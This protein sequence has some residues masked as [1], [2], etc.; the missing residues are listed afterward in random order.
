M[1]PAPSFYSS[2]LYVFLKI[3]FGMC[4]M[5]IKNRLNRVTVLNR[6]EGAG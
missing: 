5:K 1:N 4:R 6:E 3:S 2:Y